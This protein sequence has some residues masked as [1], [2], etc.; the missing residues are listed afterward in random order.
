[1][2]TMDLNYDNQCR[3]A[4]YRNDKV[5]QG[6]DGKPLAGMFKADPAKSNQYETKADV[7]VWSLGPDRQADPNQPANVGLNKDNILSWQ[8]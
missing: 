1:M 8:Q 4:F 2:I 3:D 7:M 5:A 6:A